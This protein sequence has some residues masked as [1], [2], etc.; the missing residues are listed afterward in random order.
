MFVCYFFLFCVG[1]YTLHH[2]RHSFHAGPPLT[3]CKIMS[4]GPVWGRPRGFPLWIICRKTRQP[5]GRIR[6]QKHRD[7]NTPPV[8]PIWWR[9]APT[10]RGV[11]Q[12]SGGLSL[13]DILPL[14]D[15]GARLISMQ[16]PVPRMPCL[17][18]GRTSA[19]PVYLVSR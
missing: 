19:A 14:L 15:W 1:P 8:Q 11:D 2:R 5:K 3:S 17:V 6:A 18:A 10:R 16:N 9:K 12:R 13:T 4:R 7:L